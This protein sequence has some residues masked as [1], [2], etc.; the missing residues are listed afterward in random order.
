MVQVFLLGGMLGSNLL[1]R[2]VGIIERFAGYEIAT[3]LILPEY[4]NLT[5]AKLIPRFIKDPT[6][7]KKVLEL[8]EKEEGLKRTS[9]FI[10]FLKW[11]NLRIAKTSLKMGIVSPQWGSQTA[12]LLHAIAWSYGFGW[13]SWIGL[14]P[15][16]NNLVAN[17][18]SAALMEAFPN[19][20]APRSVVES[21]YKRGIIKKDQLIEYYREEGYT[22]E[23][24]NQFLKDLE[25]DIKDKRKDLTK[26]EIL[27]AFRLK[28]F[29]KEEARTR[30]IMIGYSPE[31]A[32]LLIEIE[33]LK[34]ELD[35][36]ERNRD[37]T[38]SDIMRALQMQL[39]TPQEAKDLL[40]SIGYDED[41][42]EFLVMLELAKLK[43]KEREK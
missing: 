27:R 25:E 38:K 31:E 33:E 8:L 42:A 4:E 37:L 40:I 15:V 34:M 39:I 1:N 35:K 17:P 12:Q 19:K 43:K 14:S 20:A 24:I 13:L 6:T 29:T 2:I 3:R 23:A 32:N 5:L 7:Q 28:V 36:K 16:L 11:F 26:S 10:E 18:A 41:E 9:D 22:Q 21:L 30:L